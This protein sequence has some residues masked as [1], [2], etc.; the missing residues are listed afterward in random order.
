VRIAERIVFED[1]R[2]VLEHDQRAGGAVGAFEGPTG[3][4]CLRCGAIFR[5]KISLRRGKVKLIS[6]AIKAK[7][8]RM[9]S[10]DPQLLLDDRYIDHAGYVAVV[11]KAAGHAVAQTFLLQ[12]DADGL[13]AAAQSAPASD[14]I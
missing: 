3:F 7:A 8:E 6:F 5:K 9:A 4:S 13:I 1:L 14:I 12:K 2:G 10:G 11:R